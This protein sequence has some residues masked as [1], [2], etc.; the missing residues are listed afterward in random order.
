[1]YKKFIQIVV[2]GF[3]IISGLIG[4][5]GGGGGGGATTPAAQSQEATI[6]GRVLSEAGQGLS[7]VQLKAGAQSATTSADGSYSL[8]LVPAAELTTVVFTK[9][10]FVSTA[11]EIPTL[12][13]RST[14][15]DI[16]LLAHQISSSFSALA[17]TT[18]NPNGAS[19]E[20]PANGLVSA[21]GQP[22]TGTVSVLASY[23]APNT[24]QALQSFAEPYLGTNAGANA[25]SAN[26]LQTAGFMEVKMTDAAGNPLQLT[27]TSASTL[28]FAANNIAGTTTSIPL[29]YYS[30]SDRVWVRDGQATRLTDGRFQGTVRHFTIWN[31]DIP[32]PAAQTATL[33]GCF[34]NTAGQP[35]NP[36]A[37]L[38]R[39]AGWQVSGR[40]F[41]TNTFSVTVPAGLPLQVASGLGLFTPFDVSAL[42]PGEV[43]RLSPCIISTSLLSSLFTFAPVTTPVMPSTPTGTG[44]TPTTTATTSSFAGNYSGSYGGNETGTFTVQINAAGQVSGSGIS[45]TFSNSSFTISGSVNSQGAVSLNAAGTAGA[46]TF[47]GTINAQ[48]QIQGLWAYNIANTGGGTFTGQRN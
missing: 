29:W 45:Q 41:T 48:G 11:K 7:G 15:A 1:M 38:V 42:Q 37:I 6:Q 34:V 28:T 23:F 8:R 35:Q 2:A 16:T 36:G 24:T 9:S 39:S 3:L 43:R 44:T 26:L 47:V 33:E 14:T 12:A 30:E 4:C 17:G 46:A 18:V 5:G 22:Y 27:S 32:F 10:G 19:I 25:S 20:I 13:N 40:S 21:S 31:L